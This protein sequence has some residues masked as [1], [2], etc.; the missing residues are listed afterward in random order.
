M[1]ICKCCGTEVEHVSRR[2]LCQDCSYRSMLDAGSQIREKKG[3]I[4]EKYQL[5]VKAAKEHKES[6][7]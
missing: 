1:A 6:I 5:R 7:K 4:Y 2:G 3:P